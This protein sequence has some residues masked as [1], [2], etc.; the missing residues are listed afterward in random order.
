MR[1]RAREGPGEPPTE[2]LAAGGAGLLFLLAGVNHGGALGER[3]GLFGLAV[4]ALA[5][6]TFFSQLVLW[7]RHRE[8]PAPPER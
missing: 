4:T 3:L 7:L 2:T 5:A 8:S 1:R 6:L